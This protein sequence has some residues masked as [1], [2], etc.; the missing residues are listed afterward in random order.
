[1]YFA[2]LPWSHC[3]LSFRIA[4]SI[5]K[6]TKYDLIPEKMYYGASFMI[7][8]PSTNRLDVFWRLS[9]ICI[10]C[11][12]TSCIQLKNSTVILESWKYENNPQ[13]TWKQPT[14]LPIQSENNHLNVKLKSPPPKKK[15]THENGPSTRPGGTPTI[16]FVTTGFYTS[17]KKN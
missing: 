2:V 8:K 12:P 15:N 6:T 1:M 5:S 11:I 16:C 7:F 17:L 3:F 4:W 14:S 10:Y 13:S 9:E